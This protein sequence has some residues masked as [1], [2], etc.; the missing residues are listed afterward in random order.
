MKYLRYLFIVF[1]IVLYAIAAFGQS[2]TPVPELQ[3]S[4]ETKS[5]AAQQNAKAFRILPR[6]LYE[7]QNNSTDESA[8]P[9]KVRGGGAY[10]SFT[11]ENHSYNKI[12]QIELQNNNF[13]SG[14]YGANYGFLYDLGNV[15][16]SSV[17]DSR[18]ELKAMIRHQYFKNPYADWEK[19]AKV[20][21]NGVTFIHS[22]PAVVGHTYILRAISYD[23]ADV[24]VAFKIVKK[25]DNNGYEIIW[26]MLKNMPIPQMVKYTDAEI[27]ACAKGVVS[28]PEFSK[29]KP[30]IIDHQLTFIG[31]VTTFQKNDIS[32]RAQICTTGII[33]FKAK[34]YD[35]P[36]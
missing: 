22:I 7:F 29:L 35:G 31:T 25:L 28:A 24:I 33:Q 1:S 18:P 16:L 14:F 23:E 17:N 21:S 8:Y 36:M 20:E 30:T 12:P 6:G 9:L 4:T 5:L 10:Y 2:Y 26:K 3:P 15:S 19:T 32:K 27:L 34:A 11:T 13:S